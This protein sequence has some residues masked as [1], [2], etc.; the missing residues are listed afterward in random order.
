MSNTAT[1]R[2]QQDA[3]EHFAWQ[4]H[5]AARTDIKPAAKIVLLRLAL[6]RNVKTGR[7]D[8]S[9]VGLATGAGVSERTAMRAIAE[10]KR[11]G[12]IAIERGNGR[13]N[14]NQFRLVISNE[15][16][17][18]ETGFVAEKGDSR[19][20]ER[21]TG[22]A[23]K[24]DRTGQKRVTQLCHPNTKENML[25]APTEPPNTGE[26]GSVALARDD[27]F[28]PR[29]AGAAFAAARAHED[30]E[31]KRTPE[32]EFGALQAAWPRPWLDDVEVDRAAFEWACREVVPA[33]IIAAAAA[34]G[35]AVEPRFLPPLAK[36]LAGRGWQKPPPQQAKRARSNAASFG[37]TRR[38]G[39]KVDL[40]RMMLQHGEAVR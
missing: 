23:L 2:R 13:G 29:G 37:K 21:V 34:W 39:H 9:Y 8:P 26:I 3:R 33:I 5:V 17:T 38:S 30:Q 28:S 24:C 6:Y 12:L 32:E 35:Q 11:K 16:V 22:G 36:W 27:N 40:T 10:A 15:R 25:G 19:E 7:C 14:R 4:E 18:R 31:S 1:S 20:R